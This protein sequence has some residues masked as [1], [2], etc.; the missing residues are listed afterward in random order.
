M[1][2]SSPLILIADDS[3]THRELLKRIL[4]GEG[5]R[6]ETAVDGVEALEQI[7]RV[8]PDLVVLDLQMPRLDGIGVLK[9]LRAQQRWVLLP[10]LLLTGQTD[11]EEK[12]RGLDAGASDFLTK[13]PEL[14]ELLAR[15]RAHLRVK[16]L[17]DELE[18]AEEVLFA[19]AKVVERRDAYTLEHTERVAQYALALG[20]AMN[21]TEGE[22]RALRQGAMLHDLGMITLPDALLQKP[23]PLTKEEWA[24]M[25]QHPAV[26]AEMVSCLQTLGAAAPIIRS[27]HERW[28]GRGYPEGL[29]G[30]AIPLLA[31]IVAVADSFDAMTSDRFFRTRRTYA[32]AQEILRQGAGHEWDPKIVAIARG[33]LPTQ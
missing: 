3:E 13:P 11:R 28:D 29:A 32:E 5:Y 2:K 30:E 10:T 15:V 9:A 19:L 26:G 20:K 4:E 23:G 24:R 33:V 27:H 18:R 31:R 17:T 25:Q 22:Q 14:S 16:H 1:D 7:E 6:I 21:L 8:G 12:V